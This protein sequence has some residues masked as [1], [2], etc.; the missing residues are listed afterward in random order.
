LAT[1]GIIANP[2]SGKD[3]RRLVAHG[4]V[5]D[6]QEKVRI[7]RRVLM[8]LEAAGI[9]KVAFMPD[10]YAIVQRAM[11]G[12]SAAI[13]SVPIALKMENNQSDSTR[14]A[15]WMEAN[16]IGCIIVLGGDGTCRAVAKGTVQVPLLPVSTGTNNVFPYMIE[17][18]VA[19]L[20]AGLIA[21]GAVPRAS[22]VYRCCRLEVL[23]KETLIDIALVDVAV[24]N[25]PFIAARAIWDMDK[26]SQIFL[27]QSRPEA[28]GLSSIGGQLVTIDPREPRGL[29]L[30]LGPGGSRVT[31][32]IAPGLLKAVPVAEYR[33]IAVGNRVGVNT[34]SCVLALDGEREVEVRKGR[35]VAVGLSDQ[36]PLVVDLAKTMAYAQSQGL[37]VAVKT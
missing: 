32:P 8:G 7:V 19:G 14:S 26:I 28:I 5:F 30:A 9:Q 21:A 24:V 20:A 35:Q 10:D 6:N 15:A 3:I 2:V 34:D 16:G 23:E 27:T 29:Y 36:G 31:A 25:A 13:D 11:G 1:V 12:C 22:G 17:A 4:S 18:T 37:L 33:V